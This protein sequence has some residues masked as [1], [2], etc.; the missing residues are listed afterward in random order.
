[1]NIPE[2]WK[3]VPV[4]PTP[5]MV[6]AVLAT[7]HDNYGRD[8]QMNCLGWAESK[9]Y[10]LAAI[11]AA[12][13]PPV[14]TENTSAG[15]VA[16]TAEREHIALRL[17]EPLTKAEL[18]AIRMKSRALP[19]AETTNWPALACRAVEAEVLRRVKEANK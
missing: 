16:E 7:A 10:V 1:M 6:A 18:L 9:S 11:D 13:T 8:D 5:E 14:A 19:E 3:L 17:P 2:G 15:R 4:E 12:P